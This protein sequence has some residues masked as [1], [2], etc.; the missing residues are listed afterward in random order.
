MK[1]SIMFV[2]LDVHK[3]SIEIA[4]AE[5]GRDDEVRSFGKVSGN[6]EALDK[7]IRKLVSKGCEL[8]FAY[9]VNDSQAEWQSH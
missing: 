8:N 2:G 6:L 4:F 3:N 7:V 9:E 5:G 1:K